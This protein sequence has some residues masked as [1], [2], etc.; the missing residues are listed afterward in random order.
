MLKSK[1]ASNQWTSATK[2]DNKELINVA[3]ST[4]SLGNSTIV[5]N[6]YFDIT[7]T[8][9]A[10]RKLYLNAVGASGEVTVK[11]ID[12]IGTASTVASFTAEV[13]LGKGSVACNKLQMAIENLATGKTITVKSI[14]NYGNE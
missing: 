14:V 8:D 6:I 5:K 9:P 4:T 12:V 10:N 7:S 13:M 1:I 2:D 3:S 11:E